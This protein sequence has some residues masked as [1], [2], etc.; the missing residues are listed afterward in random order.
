MKK[1]ILKLDN[2]YMKF[3][4]FILLFTGLAF[5]SFNVDQNIQLSV[6]SEVLSFSQRFT[7]TLA[8]MIIGAIITIITITFSS[9]LVVMTLY[10]GQ[11]SPRTLGDFLQRKVPVNVLAYFIG[12]SIYAL[13]ILVLSSRY[14]LYVYPISALL[15]MIL[16]ALGITIFAYYIRYVSKAIQINIYMDQL[17]NDSVSKIEEYKKNIFENN[18]ISLLKD[19]P[20]DLEDTKE[21]KTPVSGYFIEIKYDKLLKY[22]MEEDA[23]M[24]VAI[25]FNEHIFEDDLVFEYTSNKKSFKFDEERF[26]EFF[27]IADEPKNHEEYL[28][29]TQKLIEIAVRALSPG[30]NDPVTAIG[31]INQLGFI[32]MK[33]SDGFDSLVYKDEEDTPRIR[34]RAIGFEK[35]LYNHFYQ[36]YLYGH[37][38]LEVLASMIRALTRI[39]TD[40]D[41]MMKD[42]IWN[43][44]LYLIKDIEP[45]KLHPYDFNLIHIEVR[46]LA[47][48]C[49]KYE[50]YKELME[51]IKS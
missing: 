42:A 37:K 36:I 43:F 27:I 28:N 14:E 48:K 44:F 26:E 6:L 21:F 40:S 31:C 19:E 33:L 15:M 23:F 47:H 49:R 9:I 16:F 8:I 24:K 30:I 25:S 18:R 4:I 41:S 46:E 13:L 32:L 45:E 10:S 2:M 35:L 20:F 12:T 1:L 29:K 5:I 7:E 17:V 50:A 51:K 34:L 38:D 39:S 11:F 3:I 22:L